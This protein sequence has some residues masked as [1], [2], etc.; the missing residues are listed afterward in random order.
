MLNRKTTMDEGFCL[1][2][3]GRF[4]ELVLR[5]QAHMSSLRASP[6]TED[7]QRLA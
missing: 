6:M 5:I 4:L 3:I 7:A 1:I 2:L